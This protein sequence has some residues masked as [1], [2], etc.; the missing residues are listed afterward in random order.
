LKPQGFAWLRE[1][2]EEIFKFRNQA[3]HPT[4]TFNDPVLH[5]EL[6]VGVERRQ[7]VFGY[8]NAFKI[9]QAT[10]SIVTELAAKGIAKNS[11]LK[12]YARSLE[13]RLDSIR[14]EPLLGLPPFEK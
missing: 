12:E 14:A 4:G 5:P 2:I 3:V 8:D 13:T 6:K 1:T 7:V 9:V 10:V 11:S